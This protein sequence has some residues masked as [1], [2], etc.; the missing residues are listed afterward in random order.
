MFER[1]GGIQSN[2]HQPEPMRTRPYLEIPSREQISTLREEEICLILLSFLSLR[3]VGRLEMQ[4]E[5][6]DFIDAAKEYV[7]PG[8]GKHNVRGCL[9]VGPCPND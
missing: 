5:M 8:Q 3:R 4:R 1:Y 6:Q 7:L 9:I 2:G